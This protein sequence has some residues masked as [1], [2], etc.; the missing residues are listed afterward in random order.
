MSIEIRQVDIN[1]EGFANWAPHNL[2]PYMTPDGSTYAPGRM[3]LWL[4]MEAPLSRTQQPKIDFEHPHL[5]ERFKEIIG[6]SFDYC[7]ITY[8]G[9]VNPIGIAPHRDAS[10][11]SYE[12]WG[13]NITGTCVFNYWEQRKGFGPGPAQGYPLHGLPS[14]VIKMEPGTLVHFNSK[15]PHQA[16]PSINRWAA[17]FWMRKA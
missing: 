17:N 3:K 10:S 13:L 4:G 1:H 9:N 5:A 6:V 14:H 12:A 11:L 15:N 7:L 8:S 2:L 16:I